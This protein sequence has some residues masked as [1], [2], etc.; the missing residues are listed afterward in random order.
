MREHLIH[1]HQLV[2]IER[3]LSQL[4]IIGR[5]FDA[6]YRLCVATLIRAHRFTYIHIH[7]RVVLSGFCLT[8]NLSDA[9]HSCHDFSLE[10]KQSWLTT[11]SITSCCW[12][13]VRS[14]VLY[15][16]CAVDGV[17]SM[18]DGAAPMTTQLHFRPD[19]M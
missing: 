11:F 4:F 1:Q 3:R 12:S 2:P 18:V 16:H 19:Q 6:N 5:S 7:C 9:N 15:P 8:V 14:T 10:L 13:F 17:G